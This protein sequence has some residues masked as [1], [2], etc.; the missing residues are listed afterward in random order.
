MIFS[1]MQLKYTRRG[2]KGMRQR[3][4]DPGAQARIG[5]MGIIRGVKTPRYS[6]KTF[7]AAAEALLLQGWRGFGGVGGDGAVGVGEMH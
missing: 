7:S 4:R 1:D 6:G 2:S 3:E 5:W